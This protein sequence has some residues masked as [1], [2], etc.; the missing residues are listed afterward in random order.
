MFF[1]STEERHIGRICGDNY[2]FVTNAGINILRKR[3]DNYLNVF[4]AN[5]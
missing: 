4:V 2:V 3:E 1:I 5:R